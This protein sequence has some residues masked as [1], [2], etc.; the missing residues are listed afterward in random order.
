MFVAV[1]TRYDEAVASL[2]NSAC[3]CARCRYPRAGL[4]GPACPECGAMARLVDLGDVGTPSEIAAALR[5]H[6]PIRCGVCRHRVT[7]SDDARC[8]KCDTPIRLAWFPEIASRRRTVTDVVQR[9][10]AWASA[11]GGAGL[12]LQVVPVAL[13]MAVAGPALALSLAGLTAA[14]WFVLLLASRR[15]WVKSRPWLIATA[16]WWWLAWMPLL[17]G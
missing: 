10:L 11:V 4:E 7:A 15:G 6:G 16:P 3:V 9:R 14:A 12:V 17:V 1:E 8:G 5:L 13:A 2:C